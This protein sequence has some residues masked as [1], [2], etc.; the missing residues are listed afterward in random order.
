MAKLLLIVCTVIACGL[1]PA[2][3]QSTDQLQPIPPARLI[4]PRTGHTE[5]RPAAEHARPLDDR[6]RPLKDEL[7]QALL[8]P[9]N[10]HKQFQARVAHNAG[11]RLCRE[12]HPEKGMAEFERGLSYLQDTPHS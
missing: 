1:K 9:G 4:K 2:L 8:K 6:C 11:T 3:A 12:G 7:E 5:A 10:A